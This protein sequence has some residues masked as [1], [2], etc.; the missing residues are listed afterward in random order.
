MSFAAVM[1]GLAATVSV[2][3]VVV[4]AFVIQSALR[5]TLQP[6]ATGWANRHAMSEVRATVLSFV[7]QAEASGEILG[8]LVLGAVAATAGLPTALVIAGAL[9]VVAAG[10]A[11]R[12]RR[13][14]G[15]VRA[16][17]AGSA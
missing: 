13:A 17:R 16:P 1:I 2:L 15:A 9:H 11:S 5:N 8:G 3:A 4:V 14:G 12:D 10:L 7:G 6:I